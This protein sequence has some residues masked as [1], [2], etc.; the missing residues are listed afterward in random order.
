MECP[1]C[2]KSRGRGYQP[3]TCEDCMGS[4]ILIPRTDIAT[5]G[6]MIAY[7]CDCYGDPTR[8]LG[9]NEEKVKSRYPDFFEAWREKQ[10]WDARFREEA[11]K[12]EGCA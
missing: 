9:W 2:K 7:F 11:K 6:E 12:L 1:Y 8:W 5:D 10:K 3:S 4:G